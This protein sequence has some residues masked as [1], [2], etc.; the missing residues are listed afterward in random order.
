MMP[1]RL[2]IIVTAHNCATRLQDTLDSIVASAGN[3]LSSCEIILVNDASEDDTQAIIERF[4]AV[5]P[6]TR[7][8]QTRLR[9]IG[10]VRN[11]AVAQARG[12]YF[13][14]RWR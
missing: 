6:Q 11:H 9:N 4:A 10:Q 7:H 1:P 2:S 3:T 13:N 12:L 14:G 8:Q 5:Y